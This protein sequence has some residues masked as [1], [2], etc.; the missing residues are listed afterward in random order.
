MTL[1]RLTSPSG[2]DKTFDGARVA[3]DAM[4]WLNTEVPPNGEQSAALTAWMNAQGHSSGSTYQAKRDLYALAVIGWFVQQGLINVEC[5]Q[6]FIVGPMHN[7]EEPEKTLDPR[8]KKDTRDRWFTQ[9]QMLVADERPYIDLAAKLRS[10]N[11]DSSNTMRVIGD[12]W[13]FDPDKHKN[14]ISH[15]D[16]CQAVG[17]INSRQ[18]IVVE[19]AMTSERTPAWAWCL[20]DP[21]KVPGAEVV[22]G[23]SWRTHLRNRLRKDTRTNPFG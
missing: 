13:K 21:T 14:L 15:F 6:A 23:G 22:T 10:A 4:M 8:A 9:G 7:A 1:L 16:T 5:Y 3:W 18:L 12:L 17:K 19:G 11:D 20:D 2:K